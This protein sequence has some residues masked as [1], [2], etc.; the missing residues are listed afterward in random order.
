MN[1]LVVFLVVLLSY[2]IYANP[3]PQQPQETEVVV[4]HVNGIMGAISG[5]T[6]LD[7]QDDQTQSV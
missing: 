3:L 1:L 2:F 4:D 7:P 6:V 5:E